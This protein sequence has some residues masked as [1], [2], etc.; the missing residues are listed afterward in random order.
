MDSG[1]HPNRKT[2]SN[3]FK[4]YFELIKVAFLLGFEQANEAFLARAYRFAVKV[5]FGLFVWVTAQAA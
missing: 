1:E 5:L 2:I 3:D 4:S